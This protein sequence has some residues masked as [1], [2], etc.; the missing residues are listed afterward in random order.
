MKLHT[1]NVFAGLESIVA[2]NVDLAPYTWY[3]IG[4]PAKYFVIAIGGDAK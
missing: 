2:E 1:A 3:R 4:G